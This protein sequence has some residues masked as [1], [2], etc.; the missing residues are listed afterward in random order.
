MINISKK[1]LIDYLKS[2]QTVEYDSIE[3]KVITQLAVIRLILQQLI[4]EDDSEPK[5]VREI[6]TP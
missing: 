1:E 3:E 2:T 5:I 6:T 4:D